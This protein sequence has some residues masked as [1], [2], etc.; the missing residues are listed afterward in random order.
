MF[1]TIIVFVE[2]KLGPPQCMK[3]AKTLIWIIISR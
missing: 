3:L 2:F 1:E